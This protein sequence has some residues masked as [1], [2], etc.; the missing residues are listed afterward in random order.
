[1]KPI[2]ISILISF[3]LAAYVGKAQIKVDLP[4]S[5][6]VFQPEQSLSQ[7]SNNSDLQEVVRNLNFAD[8]KRSPNWQDFKESN[9]WNTPSSLTENNAVTYNWYAF[10]LLCNQLDSTTTGY[11]FANNRDKKLLQTFYKNSTIPSCWTLN[12]SKTSNYPVSY[13]PNSFDKYNST[14]RKDS[15]ASNRTVLLIQTVQNFYVNAKT[16]YTDL[17]S[18]ITSSD[19]A[20]F[21]STNQ[22]IKS[23]FE[24]KYKN[25]VDLISRSADEN[26][27]ITWKGD[28]IFTPSSASLNNFSFKSD[29]ILDTE[30]I[31]KL[32]EGLE[33]DFK[34]WADKS[35]FV[36]SYGNKTYR[37]PTSTEVTF[38]F[39]K[40]SVKNVVSLDKTNQSKFNFLLNS[41]Y[42]KR[43]L[44]P[45]RT[46]LFYTTFATGVKTSEFT[47]PL[48]FNVDRVMSIELP[49]SYGALPAMAFFGRGYKH[50]VS[51][52]KQ[53]FDKAERSK[54]CATQKFMV[55]AFVVGTISGGL[56]YFSNSFYLN[57]PIKHKDLLEVSDISKKVLLSSCAGYSLMV[58]IDFSRTLHLVKSTKRKVAEMN[59]MLDQNVIYSK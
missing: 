17:A 12:T 42:S 10:N 21:K 18:R 43:I 29:V 19:K 51:G 46:K 5:P 53:M 55:F 50:G 9:H 3:L 8:I 14:F 47:T 2:K 44:L 15:M 4:Y 41:R 54:R 49:P 58:V 7:F 32:T 25:S 6:I 45:A 31:N 27:T 40:Q 16:P 28:F 11:R 39:T 57:D 20:K 23:G 1:M 35:Y 59:N 37:L 24:N 36:A 30:E 56:H 26:F 13:P 34:D 48:E 33:S 22:L 38:S 52:S